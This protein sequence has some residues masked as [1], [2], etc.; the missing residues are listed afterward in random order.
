M[1]LLWVTFDRAVQLADAEHARLTL[2][3]T[4][5]PARVMRWLAPAAAQSMA[6][7]A[8]TFDSEFETMAGDA[9]AR[10]RAEAT[11]RS[12]GHGLLPP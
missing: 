6:I 11:L 1:K 7:A 4:T 12:H 8:P 3:K 10:A 2:A 9:L 5:D